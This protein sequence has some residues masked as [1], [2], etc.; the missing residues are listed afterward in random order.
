M[1]AVFWIVFVASAVAIVLFVGDDPTVIPFFGSAR[2]AALALIATC[3]VI[4]AVVVAVVRHRRRIA[5]VADDA[6]V[7]TLAASVKAKRTIGDKAASY[8]QRIIDRADGA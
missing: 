4:A 8:R 2:I 6:A 3:A 7:A 1:V 5:R